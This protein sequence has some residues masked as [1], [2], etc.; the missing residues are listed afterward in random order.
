VELM[1]ITAVTAALLA[2][3]TDGGMVQVGRCM[4]PGGEEVSEQER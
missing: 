3:F 1:V 4:A 2:T